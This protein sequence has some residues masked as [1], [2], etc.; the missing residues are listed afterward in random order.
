VVFFA[1][2]SDFQGTVGMG[3]PVEV[4]AEGSG[5]EFGDQ[6]CGIEMVILKH[7]QSE[8]NDPHLNLIPFQMLGD[9]RKTD[10]VHFKNGR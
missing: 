9:G 2:G 8:V 3:K 1:E 6:P 10:R 5:M 7:P 4:Y